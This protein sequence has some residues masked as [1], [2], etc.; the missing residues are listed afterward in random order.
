MAEATGDNIDTGLSKGR[1]NFAESM[2]QWR[3]AFTVEDAKRAARDITDKYTIVVMA[4]GGC[5][6][7]ISAIRAGFKPIWSTET[8]RRQQRMWFDLTDTHCLGDTFKADLTLASTPD[9][10]TS[11]MPCTDYSR[12]GP[13]TGQH[14]ETG[15]MFT[16]QVPIILKIKPKAIR[17]E[18]S[19]HAISVN[20]GKEVEEVV[21]GL[22]QL[23]YIKVELIPVWIHGDPTAR[24]RLFIVGF[25]RDLGPKSEVNT[26]EFPK[27]TC[28]ST[29]Y[30]KL[31][32]IA[33]PDSEVPP[34][35]WRHDNPMRVSWKP[36][37]PGEAHKIAQAGI[38]MGHSSKPNVVQSWEG[39]GNSQTTY[40]GGGRRPRLDWIMNPDKPVGKT[41]MATPVEAIRMASLSDTYLDWVKTIIDPDTAP[42]DIVAWCRC[43]A[44]C[45]NFLETDQE[46]EWGLCHDCANHACWGCGGGCDADNCGYPDEK[47]TSEA[48]F[49]F[50]CVNNG[51]PNRT[52]WAIDCAVMDM[53]QKL[54]PKRQLVEAQ[55]ASTKWKRSALLDTGSNLR[56]HHTDVE[57]A[58]TSV[59]KS[60]Y[61]IQV[62]NRQTISGSKDG[63]M[64]MTVVNTNKYEGIPENTSIKLPATTV[65]GISRELFGIDD[66]YKQGYSILLRNP[67][68]ECGRPEI[69]KPETDT[70][71]AIRLPLRY[72][73][74][75]SGFWVDYIIGEN[76]QNE[77]RI[78]MTTNA[79][80]TAFSAQYNT[81]QANQ[82][83]QAAWNSEDITE[84]IYGQ[85]TE[86]RNILG[87]KSGLRQRK[88]QLTQKDFHEEYGH[89]GSQPDCSIR[90]LTQAENHQSCRQT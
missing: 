60:N 89:L 87:V 23:Y 54:D 39:L 83:T 9:Y 1:V 48:E 55:G 88:Q 44:Y 42:A 82:I 13:N 4:C 53:L 51:I 75:K 27:A 47:A 70:S 46:M 40:N 3:E 52:C 90:K 49:I 6:D 65:P 32:D 37:T 76:T 59:R 72:D 5:V 28:D 36:A 64:L 71:P 26:F 57:S 11:G 19:D 12:S 34:S 30:P 35:Y 25:R 81:S 80:A 17:L 41:R 33:I 78:A 16:A 61:L 21:K 10:L 85:H 24:R 86:G 58:L 63:Q 62:A 18:I 22:R 74:H 79:T 8:D 14:G 69:F 20:N 45:H 29:Q 15:W 66:L 38:G 43:I 68:Y 84:V 73:K 31:R 77:D 67:N 7:T 56:L 2:R 50:K